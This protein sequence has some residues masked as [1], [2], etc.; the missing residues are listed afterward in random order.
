MNMNQTSSALVQSPATMTTETGNIQVKLSWAEPINATDPKSTQFIVEF[1]NASTSQRLSNVTYSVHILLNG[2]GVGHLHD[3]NATDG[4]GIARE[5]FNSTGTLNL[6]IE[7][8][9]VG[10]SKMDQTVQFNIAVTPELPVATIA[11]GVA[12]SVVT[13]IAIIKRQTS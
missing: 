4:I 12:L 11:F 5:K 8:L 9:K 6:F 3:L 13:A 2:V 10:S 7:I 1:L